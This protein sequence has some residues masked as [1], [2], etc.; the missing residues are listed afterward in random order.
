MEVKS[1]FLNSCIIEEVYV[2]QPP[3][4]EDRGLLND[5]YN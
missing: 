2:E 1:V 5:A 4:F 3:A